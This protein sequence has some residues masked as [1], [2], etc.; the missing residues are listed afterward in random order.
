MTVDIVQRPGHIESGD[1]YHPGPVFGK[2][3]QHFARPAGESAVEVLSPPSPRRT[4]TTA[5]VRTPVIALC[6]PVA[7]R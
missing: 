5:E 7:I 3:E 1:L 4:S 2:G 6:S